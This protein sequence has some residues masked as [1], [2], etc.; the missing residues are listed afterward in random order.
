MSNNTKTK[1]IQVNPSLL[2]PTLN[3]TRK[4]RGGAGDA[5]E[6]SRKPIVV[7]PNN[8]KSKL[9]ERIKQH[10]NKEVDLHVD[11]SKLNNH[12][13]NTNA[14]SD[15][16]RDEFMD[17]IHYLSSLKKQKQEQQPAKNKTLK[18]SSYVSSSQHILLDLPDELKADS[19]S[20]SLASESNATI[21]PT[22]QPI[23]P[24]KNYHIDNEVP[25]GCLKGGLKPTFKTFNTLKNRSYLSEPQ[26]QSQ[27]QTSFSNE[28]SQHQHNPQLDVLKEK[29]RSMREKISSTPIPSSV[30]SPRFIPSPTQPA[31]SVI[32]PALVNQHA[33]SPVTTAVT[34][35]TPTPVTPVITSVIPPIQ[36]VMPVT[37]ATPDEPVYV[38]QNKTIRKTMRKTYTLGKS[39]MQKKVGVLI[40]NNHTRKQIVSAQREMKK[41]PINDVKKYLREHGL[42]KSGSNA[43]NDIV[44]TIYE[45]SMLTGDITNNDDDIYLHN[46]LKEKE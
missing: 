38:P 35:P 37:P 27:N 45:S 36:H 28:T 22:I 9:I 30:E 40:K 19:F 4:N 46:F 13:T 2:V 7:T 18:H 16:D 14:N 20:R 32:T 39:K 3:K 23:Q 8:I 11:T 44:R 24:S 42:I 10:K 17:S 43:P 34:T 6:R 25:Y 41:K 12:N 31:I 15:R 5:K 1:T 21:Q 26:S 33:M 29:M